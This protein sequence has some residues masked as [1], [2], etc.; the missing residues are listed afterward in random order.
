MAGRQGGQEAGDGRAEREVDPEQVVD[1]PHRAPP[2]DH[3]QNGRHRDECEPCPR[4]RATSLTRAHNARGPIV[5]IVYER[6]VAGRVPQGVPA[7]VVTLVLVLPLTIAFARLFAS[8]FE[9]PFLRHRTASGAPRLLR[10][11]RADGVPA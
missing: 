2:P 4:P 6:I 11:R 10:L 5:V 3:R 9:T 7:L 1:R 8:V